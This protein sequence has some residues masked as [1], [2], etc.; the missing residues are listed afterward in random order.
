MTT[1][2]RLVRRLESAPGADSRPPAKPATPRDRQALPSAAAPQQAAAH[3][4]R[5]QPPR[6]AHQR[7]R[8]SV[9]RADVRVRGRG[10]G[11]ADQ[12]CTW[13]AVARGTPWS[14]RNQSQRERRRSLLQRH[15]GQLSA[16]W[17]RADRSQ[18]AGEHGRGPMGAGS[19]VA[20][21]SSSGLTPPPSQPS[22]E[23]RERGKGEGASPP[24]G[25]ALR[26]A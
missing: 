4:Q 1:A 25:S 17:R 5:R 12:G 20:I 2:F 18:S 23:V 14:C 9:M 7:R 16:G 10:P 19:A 13:R 15:A 26:G 21:G 6:A 24:F 11:A 3:H 8:S 22:Q